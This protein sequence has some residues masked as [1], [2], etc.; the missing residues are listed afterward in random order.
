MRHRGT[1]APRAEIVAA[2]W[3]VN[4]GSDS[5]LLEVYVGYLRRKV[6]EPFGRNAI[7]T[8]R[9]HGYRFAADGG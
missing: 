5:N 6:D 1:V 2:V 7:Q 9:G 8:V 3:D 4:V